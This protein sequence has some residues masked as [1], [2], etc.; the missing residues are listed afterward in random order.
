MLPQ[1]FELTKLF[2]KLIYV[3]TLYN[4][5][6]GIFGL[7]PSIMVSRTVWTF[8]HE[9]PWEWNLSIWMIF[10]IKEWFYFEFVTF[11]IENY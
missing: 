7:E 6:Q 3:I 10:E 2:Q 5:N 11:D 8:G 1:E 4:R 9:C